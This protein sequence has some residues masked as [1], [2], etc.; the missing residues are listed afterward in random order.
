M[1]SLV[2]AAPLSVVAYL[3]FLLRMLT[4]NFTS[5]GIP[6]TIGYIKSSGL[7]IDSEVP[8]AVDIDGEPVT[9]TPVKCEVLPGALRINTGPALDRAGL[10]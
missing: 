9:R 2:V 10:P 8:L 7:S 4:G 6:S 5:R 1:I 3:S